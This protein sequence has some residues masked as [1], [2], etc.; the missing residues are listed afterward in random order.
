MQKHQDNSQ[1]CADHKYDH[2]PKTEDDTNRDNRHKQ[3][4]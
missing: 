1:K 3:E 4:T 2:I